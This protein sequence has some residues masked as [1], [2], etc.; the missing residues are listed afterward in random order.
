MMDWQAVAV[1]LSCRVQVELVCGREKLVDESVVKLFAAD[2]VQ[3]VSQR[4]VEVEF[5]HPDI[6]GTT[7]YDMVVWRPRGRTTDAIV[8]LKWIRETGGTR[9]W[10]EEVVADALRVERA[11]KHTDSSTERVVVVAGTHD[12][13]ERAL[14][15]RKVNQGG[16]AP[17]LAVLPYALQARL[18]GGGGSL[19]TAHVIQKVSGCLPA[20]KPIFKLAASGFHPTAPKSYK[21]QLVA[22]HAAN[23]GVKGVEVWIWRVWRVQKRK[24]LDVSGW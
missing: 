8:E 6:P 7:R 24:T 11:K 18:P 12:E 1:G 10:M 9:G 17:R 5:N 20:L 16:A 4:K 13:I 23:L 19:P 21:I 3:A 14:L 15:N 2:V 22:H